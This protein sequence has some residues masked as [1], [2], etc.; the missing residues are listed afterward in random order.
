MASTFRDER[1]AKS[2]ARLAKSLPA[3]FPAEVLAHAFA[4]PFIPPTP[5]L[6]IESYW[7]NHP[8]RADRLA[9]ALAAQT[10]HPEGWEWRIGSG[11]EGVPVTFRAPPAPFR[12]AGFARGPGHCR[13]CGAPVFRLGWHKDLWGDGKLNA[14]AEWHSA[15]VTAWRLWTAPSDFFTPLSKL[16]NR[17]CATSGK[18]LLKTAEV[19]HRLPLFRVWRDRRSLP[20][21]ELL[22]HWGTPNLQVINRAVHVDKCGAE[23]SERSSH[24]RLTLESLDLSAS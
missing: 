12:Q 4:R 10:S 19:D 9:R 22:A 21:P 6:A 15:C 11:E 5:R 1:N 13:V 18:R 23:A 14:R 2:R 20:W 7:R 17:R 16:Q 24:A 3:V 8:V